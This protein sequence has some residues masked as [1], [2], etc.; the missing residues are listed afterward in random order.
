MGRRSFARTVLA[1]HVDGHIGPADEQ[2]VAL[3]SGGGDYPRLAV[4]FAGQF[5]LPFLFV[6]FVEGQLH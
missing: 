2:R 3:C 6:N 1:D 5:E 4:R